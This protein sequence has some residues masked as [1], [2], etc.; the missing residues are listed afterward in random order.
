MTKKRSAKTRAGR[1]PWRLSTCSR[2]ALIPTTSSSVAAA[3]SR[4][5][6]GAGRAVGIVHLTSGEAG[7]RG[8]AEV[9]RRR[10]RPRR[11]R[12]AC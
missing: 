3:R 1:D 5:L 12:S 6:A 11:E 9:R 10:P 8:S 2:W 4:C 7:S